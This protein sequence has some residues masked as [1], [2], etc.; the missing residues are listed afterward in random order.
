MDINQQKRVKNGKNFEKLIEKSCK[1]YKQL[2]VAIIYKN[3]EPLRPSG[4]GKGGG[5]NAFYSKKSVPDFTGVINGGRTIMI[6]AKH[7]TGKSM[8]FSRVQEHQLQYLTDFAKL[9]AL[10]FI[11]IS[12][13]M[14]DYYMVPLHV[15]VDLKEHNGKKSVNKK[16]LEEHRVNMIDG[17]L[18]FL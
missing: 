4:V 14:T 13:E 1:R 8:P 16:E 18:N 10:S 11:L 17:S 2:G 12:F 9:G 3:E 6:E 7:V 15:F 5:F